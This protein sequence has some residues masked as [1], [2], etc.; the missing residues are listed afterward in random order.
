M[1]NFQI[2][3]LS[4]PLKGPSE[5]REKRNTAENNNITTFLCNPDF[6]NN[7]AYY[8]TLQPNSYKLL[9]RCA[10][11]RHFARLRGSLQGYER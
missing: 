8:C 9:H 4:L 1:K 11:R 5:L 2:C 3:E 10:R 6:G 7:N